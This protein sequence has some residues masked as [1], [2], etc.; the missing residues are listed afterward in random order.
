MFKRALFKFYKIN[1]YMRSQEDKLDEIINEAVLDAKVTN[2]L[3]MAAERQISDD[4]L[5]FKQALECL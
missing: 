3:Y 2:V 1:R 5:N 4:L